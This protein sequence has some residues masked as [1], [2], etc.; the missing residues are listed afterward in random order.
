[1]IFVMI[2]LGINRSVIPPFFG[3]FMITP[4]SQSLGIYFFSQMVLKSGWSILVVR[5]GSVLKSSAFRLYWPGAFSFFRDSMAETI[6]AF[7]GGS[8]PMSRSFSAC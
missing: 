5:S 1:M 2:L 7:V 3:I 4:S 8:M 6:S